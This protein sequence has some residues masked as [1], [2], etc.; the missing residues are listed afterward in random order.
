MDAKL[1]LLFPKPGFFLADTRLEVR[2]DAQIV[3]EG[4]FVN[5]FEHEAQ[6]TAGQHRI[7][8][9]IFLGSMARRGAQRAAAELSPRP[10]AHAGP[11][12][13]RRAASEG[14]A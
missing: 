14:C 6:V 10:T 3:Y 9:A 8:T 5:G 4:S 2:L 7:E 1:R 13:P 11:G 12:R